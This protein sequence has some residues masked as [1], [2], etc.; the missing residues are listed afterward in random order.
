MD[1]FIGSPANHAKNITAGDRLDGIEYDADFLRL[2]DQLVRGEITTEQ[3]IAA[4]KEQIRMALPE[5]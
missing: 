1:V 2:Q 5:A 4:I 3:A